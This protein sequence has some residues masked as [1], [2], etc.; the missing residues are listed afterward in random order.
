MKKSK[1]V[2][3]ITIGLSIILIGIGITYYALIRRDNKEIAKMK[4]NLENRLTLE[5]KV[6]EY[7]SEIKLQ[8]LNLDDNVKVYI[9]SQE[10]NGT[11]KFTEIGE[12]KLKAE[13]SQTYKRF[14]NKEEIITANKEVIINVEDNNKPTIDGVSDKEIT[15]GDNIDLKQGITA[16]DEIDGDLEVIIEGEVDT[17]KVGEYEI[18]VKATDK[19]NNTTE[20][21]YKVKVNAKTGE[22]VKSDNL[23]SSNQSTQAY[24]NKSSKSTTGKSTNSKKTNISNKVKNNSSTQNKSN[25]TKDDPENKTNSS[26]D[27]EKQIIYKGTTDGKKYYFDERGVNGNYGEKF[28]W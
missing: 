27:S 21:T 8:E 4:Q 24:T 20:V 18:K 13:M 23:S 19:N 22:V 3:G 26:E 7:G 15:E 28:S 9:N 5:N 17:N 2:L 12:Y 11:Y 6:Y 25:S 16:R 1:K 14:L 10:L